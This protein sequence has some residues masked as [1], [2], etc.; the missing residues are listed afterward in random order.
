MKY[1]HYTLDDF[2]ADDQFKNWVLTPTEA[3]NTFWQEWIRQH[4]EKKEILAQG[5]KVIQY[6]SQQDDEE[7]MS[8]QS[9]RIWE[10]LAT[11]VKENKEV[12][13]PEIT[14]HKYII[15]R[16]IAAVIT[17]LIM[18]G[19]AYYWIASE[20]HTIEVTTRYSEIKSIVLPDSSVIVLNANS[21]VVYQDQ[22]TLATPREIWLEGE[23]FFEVRNLSQ[24]TGKPTEI[25]PGHRFIVHTDDISVEVLGTQFNIN[26]RRNTSSV[27]LKTGSVKVK[28]NDQEA[29]I[30]LQPGERT[31]YLQV[32]QSFAREIVNPEVYTAWRN[33]QYVFDDTPIEEIAEMLEQNHGLEVTVVASAKERTFTANVPSNDVEMLLNLLNETLGLK[34]TRQGNGVRIE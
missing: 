17:L 30:L 6:L 21:S 32:S 25:K 15:W 26:H 2:L 5:R 8:A 34:I 33:N 18:S 10:R 13:L 29:D 9:A 11:S 20:S 19:L 7:A 31:E 27:V 24:Q 3:E 4:P 23:A 12:P 28:S 1:D 14:S 22:W 16:K